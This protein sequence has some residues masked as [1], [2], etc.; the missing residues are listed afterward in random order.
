MITL[1]NL[2]NRSTYTPESFL[3]AV[4]TKL[5]AAGTPEDKLQYS[6]IKSIVSS[7]MTIAKELTGITEFMPASKLIWVYVNAYNDAAPEE[8]DVD[9]IGEEGPTAEELAQEAKD[10]KRAELM[11]ELE[12]LT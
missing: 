5:K 9:C 1:N 2:K 3:D 6:S 11:A 4:N 12:Q 8:D 7:N 10:E